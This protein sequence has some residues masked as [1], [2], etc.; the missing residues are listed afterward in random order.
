[1]RLFFSHDVP[2]VIELEGL[3]DIYPHVAGK[4]DESFNNEEHNNHEDEYGFYYFNN[5]QTGEQIHL[6][7]QTL[8]YMRRQKPLESAPF[9]VFDC[10]LPEFEERHF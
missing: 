5:N 2:H 10:K 4:N 1:M 7:I 9:G 6:E 3:P 8:S